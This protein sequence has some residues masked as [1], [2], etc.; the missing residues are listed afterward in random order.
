MHNLSLA[1][2]Y[3]SLQQTVG[4]GCHQCDNP[5]YRQCYNHLSRK[6]RLGLVRVQHGRHLHRRGYQY[7]DNQSRVH[8]R[9][10]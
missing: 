9:K 5:A 1:Q 3:S 10:R 2:H 4:I 6:G 7:V 8:S